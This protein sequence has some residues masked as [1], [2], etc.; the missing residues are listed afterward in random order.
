MLAKVIL[1]EIAAAAL[2]LAELRNAPRS[3]GHTRPNRQPVALRSQQLEQH[4]M[5]AIPTMVHQQRWRLAPVQ[6][7]DIHAAIIADISKR[8]SPPRPQRNV[9]EPCRSSNLVKRSI[10]MIAKQQHGLP[11]MGR[12]RNRIHL[13]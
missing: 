11:E 8:R 1:R 12:V 6:G 9:V 10:P 5:V 2:H 4:A 13:W 3:N 7:D